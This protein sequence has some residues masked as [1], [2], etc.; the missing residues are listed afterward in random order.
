MAQ[1]KRK[2]IVVPATTSDPPRDYFG[3][4]ITSTGWISTKLMGCFDPPHDWNSACARI[5]SGCQ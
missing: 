5:A 1:Q 4:D 3:P 2:L